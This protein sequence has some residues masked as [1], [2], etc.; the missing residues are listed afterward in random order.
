[1]LAMLLDALSPIGFSHCGRK[2]FHPKNVLLIDTRDVV[3]DESHCNA[4]HVV[5][6]LRCPPNDFT[7][8]TLSAHVSL[9]KAMSKIPLDRGKLHEC[10]R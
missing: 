6:K 5:T 3:L 2:R 8:S 9:K 1:M 10:A 4:Q 7:N